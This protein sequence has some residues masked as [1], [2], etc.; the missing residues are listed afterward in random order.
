MS[1]EDLCNEARAKRYSLIPR[2]WIIDESEQVPTNVVSIPGKYLSENEVEITQAST[3]TILH[4]IHRGQWSAYCVVSAFCHRA[5]IAQQ[6][7][8]CLSEILF[9]EALSRAKQLDAILANTGKVVGPLHG[10]PFSLKDEF[11]LIDVRSTLCLVSKANDDP[12]SVSSPNIQILVDQGAIP[13]AKTTTPTAVYNIETASNLFGQTLNPYNTNF[14]SGGSSGGESALLALRG[15]PLG[16]GSDLGGSIR[17][18]ASVTGIYGLRMTTQRT[19]HLC[20]QSPVL[21]IESLKPT[22]GPMANDV[23]SLE[24]YA[25]AMANEAWKHDIN[26]LN[27][28]WEI[29]DSKG[30]F[31]F[32]YVMDAGPVQLTPPVKRAMLTLVQKLQ[33]AG[34]ECV[35]FDTAIIE[36]I[37][38]YAAFMESSGNKRVI[39]ECLKSGEPVKALS[40][41][42]AAR[43]IPTSE[44]WVAQSER[45]KS[46]NRFW[47]LWQSSGLDGLIMPVSPHAGFKFGEFKDVCYS[48]FANVVDF[49]ACTFPVLTS[50]RFIDVAVDGSTSPGYEPAES[51]G[52]PVGVQVLGPRLEEEK[53][54]AM[55]T[56]LRD[57]LSK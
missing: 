44:M 51:D 8:N 22:N 20:L 40:S 5:A 3:A 57:I 32:G 55:V 39:E 16:V 15:S 54:L 21:G 10:L 34:L 27:K 25:K 6:L 4:N 48:P 7:V 14:S 12:S 38:A 17:Q 29:F 2:E 53:V 35:P 9:E 47:K 13:I 18:P 19:S 37:A 30:H 50:D 26:A 31:K 36:E 46:I 45:T 28:P 43:D 23:F 11:D 33:A 42:Q 41:W 24:L 52:V 1:W 56:F 49:P